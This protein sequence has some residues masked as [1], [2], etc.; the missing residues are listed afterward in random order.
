MELWK[1]GI[2]NYTELVFVIITSTIFYLAAIIS[3]LYARG[4]TSFDYDR[5]ILLS[6]IFGC[7][8]SA[9]IVLAVKGFL[10]FVQ[11]FRPPFWA[12][13]VLVLFSSIPFLDKIEIFGN[14][15]VDAL[16]MGVISILVILFSASGFHEI[17]SGGFS[18][19]MVKAWL[20]LYPILSIITASCLRVFY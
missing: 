6:L 20:I 7:F 4:L 17:F 19:T 5:L 9:L 15:I 2:M 1:G 16:F 14:L 13:V 10:P 3:L 18:F 12:M 11:G 8:A